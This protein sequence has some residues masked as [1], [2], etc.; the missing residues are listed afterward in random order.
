[1]PARMASQTHCENIIVLDVR[2]LSPITDFFVIASGTS[3]RQMKS[4]AD[5]ITEMAKAS[6][7]RALSSSGLESGSWVL[8]DFIDVIVHLFSGEARL[9][10]DL[11]NLWGDAQKVEWENGSV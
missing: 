3:D 4:V 5:E 10:Y 11:E 8:V 2:G 6:G 1:M 9:Y 7:N